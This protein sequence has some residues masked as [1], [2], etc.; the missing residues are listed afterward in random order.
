LLLARLEP[1]AAL[2]FELIALGAD[3]TEAP[4]R[5]HRADTCTACLAPSI[6]TVRPAH[7]PDSPALHPLHFP[8][9]SASK[10][11]LP[12]RTFRSRKLSRQSPIVLAQN[13]VAARLRPASR[14]INRDTGQLSFA[15]QAA[16]QKLAGVT[17]ARFSWSKT[18]SPGITACRLRFPPDTMELAVMPLLQPPET[19]SIM[20]R[21][22][23]TVR[24][25]AMTRRSY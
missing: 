15:P 16:H 14:K 17:D 23:A 25:N 5:P 2:R 7:E 6:R 8:S 9:A 1:S 10:V 22:I 24:G 18:P 3:P 4:P 19:W 12:L 11:P 13:Q 20:L 21:A